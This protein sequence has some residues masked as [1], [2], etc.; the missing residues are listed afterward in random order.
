MALLADRVQ[1]TTSSTG[2]GTINL[3]G[4]TTGYQSFTQAFASGVTVYYCISDGVNWEAGTGVFTTGTPAT[5]SRVTVLSS[6]NANAL[7]S[8]TAGTKSVFCTSPANLSALDRSYNSVSATTTINAGQSMSF[9]TGGGSIAGSIYSDS[10]WGVIFRA[11][12]A[13]PTIADFDF[14][15][16]SGTSDLRILVTSKQA[17][18]NGPMVAGQI[19]SG[20]Y[21]APQGS[22]GYN[23]AQG[24]TLFARTGTTNDFSL[25]NPANNQYILTVPTG[26]TNLL[27]AA[28]YPIFDTSNSPLYTAANGYQKLVS[29]LILQWGIATGIPNATLTN[30]SFPIAFPT[31]CVNVQAIGTHREG[32]T[33]ANTAITAIYTS[34]FTIST[35]N[36]TTQSYYWFAIGY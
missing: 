1:E 17:V 24:L 29:G 2:I 13:S 20:S 6:S 21:G 19:N 22:M 9:G 30:I 12:Q 10:N 35:G 26:T 5:L 25:I 7:V 23:A 11:K 28:V 34:Y 32:T 18:F 27:R 16:S 36:P 15:D 3:G 31:A 14:Q 4:A 33:V 8:F